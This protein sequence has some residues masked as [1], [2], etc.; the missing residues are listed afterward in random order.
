M[1]ILA[2]RIQWKYELMDNSKLEKGLKEANL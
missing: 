1:T 2:E